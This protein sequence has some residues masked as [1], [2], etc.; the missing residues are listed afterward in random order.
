MRQLYLLLLLGILCTPFTTQAQQADQKDDK[1]KKVIVIKK[2]YEK[3]GETTI[4]KIILNEENAEEL[5]KEDIFMM[6]GDQKDVWVVKSGEDCDKAMSSGEVNVTVEENDG[7]KV[8]T[9]NRFGE[10][11]TIE[12]KDGESLSDEQR[13]ELA[14]QGIS[15]AQD[16]EHVTV[17]GD[18]AF[19]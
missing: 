19:A 12:L 1:D 18:R 17:T 16:G 14:E 9:V 8:I 3:D 11:E 5:S 4:E 13:A 6:G 7:V 10:V 15:I 2:K